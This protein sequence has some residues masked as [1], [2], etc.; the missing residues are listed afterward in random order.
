MLSASTGFYRHRTGGYSGSTPGGGTLFIDK[1]YLGI[2]D[3]APG[4]E[5]QHQAVGQPRDGTPGAVRSQEGYE[6]LLGVV[7]RVE[8][9]EGPVAQVAGVEAFDL[10]GGGAVIAL[11]NLVEHKCHDFGVL[12]ECPLGL[13]ETPLA[14][15]SGQKQGQEQKGKKVPSFHKCAGQLLIGRRG[16]AIP[17]RSINKS[18]RNRASI[19]FIVPAF[20]KIAV[21]VCKNN[22]VTLTLCYYV[23]TEYSV[24]A[25]KIGKN[26]DD[27]KTEL[28]AGWQENAGQILTGNRGRPYLHTR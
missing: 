25:T 15:A 7:E 16:T 12:A 22:N 5:T 26:S 21:F 11:Q 14:A 10:F 8:P 13:V 23:S 2:G 28:G 1:R 6:T 18:P 9:I 24:V 19:T 20:L 27:S 17:K 3:P 4:V